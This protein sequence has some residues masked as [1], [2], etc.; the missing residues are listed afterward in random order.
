MAIVVGRIGGYV[1]CVRNVYDENSK[2]NDGYGEV[3]YRKSHRILEAVG[4]ND[5]SR[6]GKRATYSNAYDRNS[7]RDL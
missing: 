1:G 6:H 3:K 7:T 4:A 5:Y 2:N